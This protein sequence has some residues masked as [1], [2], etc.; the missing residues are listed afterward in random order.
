M[1]VMIVTYPDESKFGS[2]GRSSRIADGRCVEPGPE[3]G[4][5]KKVS[6][7]TINMNNKTAARRARAAK[8]RENRREREG[9][10]SSVKVKSSWIPSDRIL[11]RT[12]SRSAPGYDGKVY[13]V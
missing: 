2:R 6:R 1:A 11:L 13:H 10:V 5:R 9:A 12:W 7:R 8:I 3:S 4:R